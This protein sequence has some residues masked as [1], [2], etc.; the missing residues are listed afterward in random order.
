MAVAG[1]ATVIHLN[2]RIAMDIATFL[3][4]GGLVA[5]VTLI[6]MAMGITTDIIITIQMV[7]IMAIMMDLTGGETIIHQRATTHMKIV[8]KRG[9]IEVSTELA[10][11][12]ILQILRSIPDYL[13]IFL[14]V[15]IELPGSPTN[16][17]QIRPR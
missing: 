10:T 3:T 17:I 13:I 9:E 7:T 16:Q 11:I 4:I 8:R 15:A 12:L 14:T 6:T 1:T 2:I 5:T